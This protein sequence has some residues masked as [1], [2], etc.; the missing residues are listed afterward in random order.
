LD[1]FR[2]TLSGSPCLITSP[3]VSPCLGWWFWKWGCCWG[4]KA[5]IL[6]ICEYSWKPWNAFKILET[7]GNY[8]RF[9]RY[10]YIW[11]ILLFQEGYMHAQTITYM[12]EC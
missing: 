1:I 5:N 2:R 4:F 10:T 11:S 6:E 12:Y 3:W 7:P 9:S 8:G